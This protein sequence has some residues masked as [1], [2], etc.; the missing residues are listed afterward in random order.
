MYFPFLFVPTLAL[1]DEDR[2]IFRGNHF[3]CVSLS[4]FKAVYVADQADKKV[5]LTT[6]DQGEEIKRA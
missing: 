6:E 4:Q 3:S 1:D 2:Q 5:T